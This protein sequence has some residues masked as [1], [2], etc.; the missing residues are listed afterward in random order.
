MPI[1][2]RL[3]NHNARAGANVNPTLLVPNFCML[4]SPKR[5]TIEVITRA[6][7]NKRGKKNKWN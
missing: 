4:N 7:E 6:S 3:K 5:I 1:E 2:P